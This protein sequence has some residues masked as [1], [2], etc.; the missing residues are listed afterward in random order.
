M[1]P[2]DAKWDDL[3]RGA[4]MKDKTGKTWKVVAAR[5][6]GHLDIVG[7]DGASATLAPR[8]PWTPV[9]MLVP[10][11]DEAVATVAATLGGVVIEDRSS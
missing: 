7:R 3:E 2:R 11:L 5:G 4:Y 8:D 6:D 9:T 10:T 1:I